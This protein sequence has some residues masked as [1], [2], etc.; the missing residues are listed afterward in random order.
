MPYF[1]WDRPVQGGRPVRYGSISYGA[2]TRT[3]VLLGSA[4]I[5]GTELGIHQLVSL[6]LVP[7]S[8]FQVPRSGFRVPVPRS[9]FAADESPPAAPFSVR[10]ALRRFR[11][12]ESS[13]SPRRGLGGTSVR[14]HPLPV[15]RCS[16]GNWRDSGA[17]GFPTPIPSRRVCISRSREDGIFQIPP[18]R[19]G[20]VVRTRAR[21][22][23]STQSHAQMPTAPRSASTSP[24]VGS[25]TERH[26]GP[27][28]D[29]RQFP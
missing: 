3:L 7:R 23:P 15:R 9:G 21:A 5:R 11:D 17:G 26:P 25:T 28:P 4:G 1:R 6:D 19:S 14:V 27:R 12:T 20:T 24:G 29:A 2:L 8:G 18:P 10:P 16:A 22:D 13:P